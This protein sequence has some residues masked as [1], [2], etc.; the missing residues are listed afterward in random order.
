[1]GRGGGEGRVPSFMTAAAE[2][3]VGTGLEVEDI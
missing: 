1:M 3:E 2:R